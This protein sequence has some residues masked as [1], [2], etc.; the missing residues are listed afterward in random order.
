MLPAQLLEWNRTEADYP[1][2]STIADLF[3]AQAAR[4]PDAVALIRTA[5]RL[6]I[7]N[8]MRAPIAWRAIC[9]ASA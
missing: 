4:T 5:A 2:S 1:R 3:A 6:L 8:S 7:A 9:R